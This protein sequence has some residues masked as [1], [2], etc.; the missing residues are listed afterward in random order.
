LRYL[1]DRSVDEI[2]GILDIAPATALVHLHRGRQAL[3]ERLGDFDPTPPTHDDPS[4]E[5]AR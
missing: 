3:R 2:A 4:G 1:E 5:T